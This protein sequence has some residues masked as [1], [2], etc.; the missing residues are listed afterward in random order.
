MSIQGLTP[1]AATAAAM[2]G[3]G[4]GHPLPPSLASQYYVPACGWPPVLTGEPLW[5]LRWASS[6][7]SSL[8]L[9]LDWES[10]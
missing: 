8:L 2:R 10:H 5:P 3:M 1:W 7:G 9:D 4:I 6:C